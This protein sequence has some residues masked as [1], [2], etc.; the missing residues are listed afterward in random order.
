H[1]KSRFDIEYRFI[2]GIA[3]K[4]KSKFGFTIFHRG[5]GKENGFIK[6]I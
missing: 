3:R 4:L 6:T 2:I 5:K 1:Y